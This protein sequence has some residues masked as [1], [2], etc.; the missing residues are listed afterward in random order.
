MSF[1][2]SV[3]GY[4]LVLGGGGITGLLLVST[5]LSGTSELGHGYPVLI[6][7]VSMLLVGMLI[8]WFVRNA[9]RT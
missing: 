8:L 4:I 3:L 7:S 1:C 5:F 2:L 9:E 6:F